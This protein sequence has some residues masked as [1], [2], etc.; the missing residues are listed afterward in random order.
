M[1]TTKLI[2]F[3][4]HDRIVMRTPVDTGRARASWNLVAGDVADLSVAPKSFSGGGEQGA[5]HAQAKA[6]GAPP[7]LQYVIS[8]N[9]PYIEK[10]EN[11]SSRQAPAGMVKLAA[12][13]VMT[14][15]QMELKS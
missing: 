6:A 5:A 15:L 7:A 2:A 9:L 4:I 13:D 8:N 11:G 14:I 12:A 1:T 10:L 3:R